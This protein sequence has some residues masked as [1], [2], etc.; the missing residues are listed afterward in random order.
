VHSTPSAPAQWAHEHA[1]E[2]QPAQTAEAALAPASASYRSPITP[3]PTVASASEIAAVHTV[4]LIEASSA[5]KDN[6]T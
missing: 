3:Q 5:R 4:L 1:S 6:G 2:L